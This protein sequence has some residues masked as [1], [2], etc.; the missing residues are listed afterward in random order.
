MKLVLLLTVLM[1][2]TVAATALM[3]GSKIARKNRGAILRKRPLTNREQSMYFRLQ[4]VLD[5]RIVLAQV[6]FS[7]L[8]KTSLQ[9]DRN[10]FDRKVADFV[11]C[12]KTFEVLAI[13]ELDDASH[14]G[15]A[16]QDLKRETLLTD[17]GYRVIRYRNVP[18]VATLQKDFNN[19]PVMALTKAEVNSKHVTK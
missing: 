11:I 14:N 1:V 3:R 19:V 13:I 5:G 9:K 4:E 16:A 10:R 8:L 15:R 17:A 7:A 6:A 18:D 12:D 2:L